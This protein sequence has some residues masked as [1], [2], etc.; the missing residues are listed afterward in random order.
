MCN[1]YYSSFLFVSVV[2]IAEYNLTFPIY[3]EHKSWFI[4][5]QIGD[6]IVKN[7]GID[8]PIP[9]NSINNRK[10]TYVGIPM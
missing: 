4:F 1:M 2:I 3:C 9:L 8:L 6:N 5:V 7:L 10:I